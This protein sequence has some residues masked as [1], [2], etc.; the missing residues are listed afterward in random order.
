MYLR[1]NYRSKDGRRHAHRETFLPCRS[2]DRREKICFANAF[3]SL[4]FEA[5]FLEAIAK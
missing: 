3:A 4:G 5:V 2:A 1:K